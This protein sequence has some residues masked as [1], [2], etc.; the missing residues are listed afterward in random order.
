MTEKRILSLAEDNRYDELKALN[1]LIHEDDVG[2]WDRI[3]LRNPASNNPE[4]HYYM[5][6]DGKI[7]AGTSLI[8]HKLRW[9][10]STID[11]GEIGL[12]GTLEEHR[13]KGYSRDLM[14]QCL[15]I[16]RS[17]GIPFS[18]LWGIP[19]FYEQF[20]YHYAYPN[21]FTAYINFPK[22]CSEKWEKDDELHPAGKD[23]HA[24]IQEL[25]NAYNRAVTGSHVRTT[26]IWEWYFHLTS[27]KVRSNPAAK[28]GWWILDGTDSGYA[29]VTESG[30]G[31]PSIVRELAA[32]SEV[33][34]KNI[35]LGI[36]DEFPNAESLDFY[37]HPEMPAGRWLYNLGARVRS[38][39]NIWKG[40]WAGMVRINDPAR[41]L[42]LMVPCLNDRLNESK[43]H[44]WSGEF[45]FSSDVG[46]AVIN[47]KDGQVG[48]HN[49]DGS[50][51]YKIPARVLTPIMTGYQGFDRFR[52]DLTDLPGEILEIMSVLFP[53]N[54]AYM[55]DLIYIDAEFNEPSSKLGK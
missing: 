44:A 15:D 20:H 24:A 6:S 9:Y 40:S 28:S 39:E 26:E 29:F 27:G 10:G 23:D 49:L 41:L 21:H 25:Y 17:E 54:I 2:M 48:I 37:H 8:R 34:L 16:M 32:T 45:S 55:H 53:R 7:I 4:F 52:N 30:E 42:R 1:V 47:I 19:N 51:R 5:T 46:G 43:F 18:F 50:P 11:A 35:V 14:N 36:F 33:S 38:S 12:V 22:S 31:K 13:K 3:F